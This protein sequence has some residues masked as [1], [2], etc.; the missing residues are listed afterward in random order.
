MEFPLGENRQSARG[1]INTSTAKGP[2][3]GCW[4]CVS[5]LVLG[6]H[7]AYL[8][9]L[10]VHS[11]FDPGMGKSL[12]P[13]LS[14]WRHWQASLPMDGFSNDPMQAVGLDTCSVV[15]SQPF[16]FRYFYV[17]FPF[18]H[19]LPVESSSPKV[20]L[21][22]W[23]DELLHHLETMAETIVG[24]YLQGII[25][26]VLRNG[27]R[28]LPPYCGWTKSCTTWGESPINNGINRQ[29]TGAKRISQPS[30]VFSPGVSMALQKWG[31]DPFLL[32]HDPLL[33]GQKET[34]GTSFPGAP[35][36]LPPFMRPPFGPAPPPVPHNAPWMPRGTHGAEWVRPA[37]FAFFLPLLCKGFRI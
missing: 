32:G 24:R 29:Q 14:D 12:E 3:G 25:I 34:P 5:D 8:T 26:P 1:N 4:P 13:A 19:F 20:N 35:F 7:I 16:Y 11:P 10:L 27:F 37:D 17:G 9:V 15:H 18:C 21:V 28:N 23:M 36:G 2:V 33:K 30:A 6:D 31:H 22:L